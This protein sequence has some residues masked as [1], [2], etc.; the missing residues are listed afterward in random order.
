MVVERRVG[1]V[2]F[3]SVLAASKKQEFQIC[4]LKRKWKNWCQSCEE[5]EYMER[6]EK[7]QQM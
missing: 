6:E 2:G 4:Q 1:S 7:E 5:V 3:F